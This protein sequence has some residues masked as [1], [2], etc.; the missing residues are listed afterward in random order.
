LDGFASAEIFLADAVG[1]SGFA[2]EPNTSDKVTLFGVDLLGVGGCEEVCLF[3]SGFLSGVAFL[4]G[5]AGLIPET[6][7]VS[8]GH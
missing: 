4:G 8:L 2:D 6:G 5:E 3:P 7:G 1:L